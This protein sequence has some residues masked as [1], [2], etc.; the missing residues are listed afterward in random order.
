MASKIGSK[1]SG[2][3]NYRA[4]REQLDEVVLKLQDPECDVDEAVGLY[5]QAL[6][7]IGKLEKCLET[8]ENRITK[9]QADF[10]VGADGSHAGVG[11]HFVGCLFLVCGVCGAAV[12][13]DADAAGQNGARHVGP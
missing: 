12:S 10:G 7:L 13:A 1:T 11:Y 3:D 5:E 2:K 8:A 6:V 9:V 4:L